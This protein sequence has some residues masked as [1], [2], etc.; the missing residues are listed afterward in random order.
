MPS[1]ILKQGA[2]ARLYLGEYQGE[3]CLI[4][5]RFVKKYRHPELDKQITRRRMKAEMKTAARC[6]AAG[7]LVPKVLHLD[8]PAHTL[9]I[10]YYANAKT[11]KE[12][13][14]ETVA[15]KEA[16]EAKKL[17][18]DLCWRIGVIVGRM[19]TDHIIH[20]DLTTSNILIDP[21]ENKYDIVF[22]DFGL[23]HY[24]KGAERKG[25]DLYVLERALLS[26]HSEQ[27]YLFEQILAGYRMQCGREGDI[28]LDKFEE[29]RARGRKRTMIG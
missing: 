16:D 12:F 14:Q 4:K 22:I 27:P 19:H 11:A 9:Y 10:E 17:L 28:V 23:S 25:V 24:D 18:L 13:I 7:V 2:E 1:E 20:G 26:T 8:Y 21:Q 3:T 5:E 15:T 6:L 29:V